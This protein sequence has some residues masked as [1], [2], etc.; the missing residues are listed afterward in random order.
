MHEFIKSPD[1][2]LAISYSGIITSED[3]DA[4]LDRFE[5]MLE[6]PG[7]IHFFLEMRDIQLQLSAM[8]HHF[9]RS[10]PLLGKLGR[11]G[12]VAV[13]ADQAWIRVLTRLESAVLPNI[14]YRVY[15]PEERKEALDFAFGKALAPA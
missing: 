3:L 2:V 15:E 14:K 5:A 12:R 10:L 11:Y 7:K 4:A 13:V 1:D 8:P 9:S 6:K